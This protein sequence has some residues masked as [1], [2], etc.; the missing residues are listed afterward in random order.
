MGCVGR[1]LASSFVSA[2]E[3][4]SLGRR[5]FSHE[6]SDVPWMATVCLEATFS[7]RHLQAHARLSYCRAPCQYAHDHATFVR[8][9]ELLLFVW[10]RSVANS[11]TWSGAVQRH[12]ST[13]S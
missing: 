10:Q 11:F 12:A 2:Q 1:L 9:A 13:P 5:S 8:C 7:C 4:Q 6:G 3:Q